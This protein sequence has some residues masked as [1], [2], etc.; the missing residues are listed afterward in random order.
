HREQRPAARVLLGPRVGE[1]PL[2]VH[3]EHAGGVLGALDV[4]ADPVERLRD[5]AQHVDLP[6]CC[7]CCCSAMPEAPGPRSGLAAAGI[8]GGSI[9][10]RGTSNGT[11][12]SSAAST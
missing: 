5:P 11:T 2:Q 10:R 6:C 12:S 4:S 8:G 7:C 9:G 3:V 1:H